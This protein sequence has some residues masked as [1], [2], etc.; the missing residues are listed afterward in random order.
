MNKNT[1][2]IIIQ[3]LKRCGKN[4]Q[5]TIINF[6]NP[7]KIHPEIV[8]KHGLTAGNVYTEQEWQ[9]IWSEN[10]FKLNLDRALNLLSIRLHT[11]AELADK[12]K[13]KGANAATVTSVINECE[14]MLLI[15]DNAFIN[16]YAAELKRRGY[17][18]L[19]LKKAFLNKKIP[20][21]LIEQYLSE[22]HDN[23]SELDLA[24]KA[25]LNKIKSLSREKDPRKR[26]EK[27]IRNLAGKGFTSDIIFQVIDNLQ[28][29]SDILT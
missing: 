25:A 11:R 26:R 18:I 8:L 7:V 22:K 24:K 27:L 17:G 12:L 19:R 1:D 21:E 13:A 14:R 9:I 4:H 5:A 3:S 29:N 23:Q 10:C 16:Q 28:Q 6:E 15:D 2:R 20:R